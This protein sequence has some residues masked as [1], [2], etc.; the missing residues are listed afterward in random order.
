MK[1]KIEIRSQ[2]AHPSITKNTRPDGLSKRFPQTHGLFLL[3][4]NIK[5]M[6]AYLWQWRGKMI[7]TARPKIAP[8][9]K[10]MI[11]WL[12]MFFSYS[13]KIWNITFRRIFR[14]LSLSAII[15]A[16]PLIV[17]FV[18]NIFIFYL[19]YSAPADLLKISSLINTV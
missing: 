6:H 3:P 18:C 16:K 13:D 15:R 8:L 2:K 10:N 9:W 17:S 4:R 7:P 14:F 5:L 1:Q 11:S 19:S 12:F